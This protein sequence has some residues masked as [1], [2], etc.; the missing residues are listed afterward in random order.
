V[1]RN[2]CRSKRKGAGGGACRMISAIS[3]KLRRCSR[4]LLVARW[5]AR[6]A[7][8]SSIT[9]WSMLLTGQ[10]FTSCLHVNSL[11]YQANCIPGH[12][13]QPVTP[14]SRAQQRALG[15][16]SRPGRHDTLAHEEL[17]CLSDLQ[18]K[19][20]LNVV[21]NHST[22]VIDCAHQHQIAPATALPP[23]SKKRS[24]TSQYKCQAPA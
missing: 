11:R 3:T 6:A 20:Y 16:L 22:H 8:R 21:S 17:W 2:Y 23:R 4:R 10:A 13:L 24:C 18:T 12:T 1:Q 7:R 14:V 9:W 5:A 15:E 19:I